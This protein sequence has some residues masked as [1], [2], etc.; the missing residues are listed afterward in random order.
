MKAT[1]QDKAC[2]NFIADPNE[3][4]SSEDDEIDLTE[5]ELRQC[6]IEYSHMQL[7]FMT[8]NSGSLQGKTQRIYLDNTLSSGYKQLAMFENQFDSLKGQITQFLSNGEESSN[9]VTQ[10]DPVNNKIRKV[11]VCK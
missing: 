11:Y 10:I 6:H 1:H 2:R 7:S 9:V 3:S 5:E 8:L 4:F